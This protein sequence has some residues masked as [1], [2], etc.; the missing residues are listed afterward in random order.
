MSTNQKTLLSLWVANYTGYLL[1]VA[2]FKLPTREVAEDTVQDTFIAAFNAFEKSQP[3]HNPKAWLHQI[4]KNKI[5]DYYRKPDPIKDSTLNHYELTAEENADNLFD[6]SGMWVESK[7]RDSL[8]HNEKSLL[9]N[10]DFNIVLA[11]CMGKLP[12]KWRALIELKYLNEKNSDE[13]CQ[14]IEISSTNYW[15][16]M[17]RAKLQLKTCIEKNWK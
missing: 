14:E 9:D 10:P 6:E 2:L 4:L 12:S 8:W 15:Q 1:R 3:V 17:H 13:I 11:N 7:Q 16:M 5:N